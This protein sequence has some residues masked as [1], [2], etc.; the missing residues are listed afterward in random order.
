[1][2]RRSLSGCGLS[3]ARSETCARASGGVPF[4]K[5]ECLRAR[6]GRCNAGEGVQEQVTDHSS[7]RLRYR[8]IDAKGMKDRRGVLLGDL[9]SLAMRLP[10]SP[11]TDYRDT[12][13]ASASLPPIEHFGFPNSVNHI[14]CPRMPES[15]QNQYL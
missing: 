11:M 3:C 7:H 8:S 9:A 13:H 4:K 5:Q 2:T 6:R 12:F 10:V 14:G 15:A 1:M